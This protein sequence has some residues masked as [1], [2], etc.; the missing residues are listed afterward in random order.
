M[1]YNEAVKQGKLIVSKI[2]DL[3]RR[4]KGLWLKIAK[5]AFEICEP[6]YGTSGKEK[7][8]YTYKK[9]AKDIGT[10]RYSLANY[11]K[12]YR[13]AYVKSGITNS[14]KKPVS[15]MSKKEL[16]AIRR[17]GLSLKKTATEKQVNHAIKKELR[18]SKEEKTLFTYL[19]HL[20]LARNICQDCQLDMFDQDLI[21]QVQEV[22]AEIIDAIGVLHCNDK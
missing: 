20:K 10:C 3:K 1:R 21:D 7:H 13:N 18:K 9:Y 4:E 17:V 8:K 14:G 19:A 5:I 22:C 12:I 2:D 16:Q 6:A 11:I 15:K